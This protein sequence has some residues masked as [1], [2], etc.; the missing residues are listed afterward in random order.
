MPIEARDVRERLLNLFP[1][2]AIQRFPQVH[3]TMTKSQGIAAVGNSAD[4]NDVREFVG[5]TF[6]L[7]HQHVHV[8]EPV[9]AP[10]TDFSQL[11]GVT[12]LEATSEGDEHH[13][14]YLVPL[15]YELVLD[16]P[17]ERHRLV[18][19][20]PLKVVVAPDH[21]RFHFTIMAKK[22]QAYLRDERRVVQSVQ[23]PTEDSLLA[24]SRHVT[25]R[26]MD[27]NLGI[28]TLWDGNLFDAARVRYKRARATSTEVMDEAFTVKRDDPGR[29]AR[30]VSK[31]LYQTTFMF[32]EREPCIQYFV[33]NPT[34]G[35][36]TF[37]RFST[38]NNC[39]D[40]VIR[41]II[42]ANR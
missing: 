7:L 28:K 18:F 27:I 34:L 9:P 24:Q 12:P 31:P 39:V 16:A 8:F 26:S 32:T 37:R 17:L 40:D 35:K 22:P 21:V 14:I 33:A 23:R 41:T 36:L 30:L 38:S 25:G 2:A 42:A 20:W 15:T 11:F 3:A 29:Y 19:A 4:L 5:T 1:A 10:G 13:Y 6:G